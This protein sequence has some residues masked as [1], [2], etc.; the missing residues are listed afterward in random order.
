LGILLLPKVS[1]L[2]AKGQTKIVSDN[3]G[4]FIPAL[5]QCAL[6]FLVQLFIFTDVFVK[7]WLGSD[8]L[9]MVPLIRIMLVSLVFYAL[10]VSVRSIL[11]AVDP[12]PLNT[13]NLLIS[14][15]VFFS[16]TG[17]LLL[18]KI[19]DSLAMHLSVAFTAGLIILGLLTYR[20]LREKFPINI[21]R[22]LNNFFLALLANIPFVAAA[23]ILKF[24]VDISLYLLVM[25]EVIFG[26][27]YLIILRILKVEWL[28]R[29]SEL[30]VDRPSISSSKVL[31]EK[32][33]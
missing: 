1:E 11:D 8:F 18:M 15:F 29:L 28:C 9:P 2:V 10:Y 22:D 30:L 5:L 17:F 26:I 21:K 16:I 4:F 12:K 13:I 33:G 7:L 31:G 32:I 14:L 25:I 3:L 24:T 19:G 6:F 27:S 23:I 20:S